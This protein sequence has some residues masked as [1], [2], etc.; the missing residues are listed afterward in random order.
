VASGTGAHLIW[1]VKNGAKSLPARVITTL[2]D[3]THLVRLRESDSMLKVRR[4]ATGDKRALRLD[5]ITARLVEFPVTTTDEA[6]QS[7]TTRFRVLTT[8]LNPKTH[9]AQEI[10]ACYAERWQV[11]LTYKAIKSTLRGSGRRLRGQAPDLA[12]QEIWALLTVCNALVDQA[13]RAAVDLGV[14]PD[15]ISL[16][17]VLNATRDH[18]ARPCESCGHHASPEDLT[19]A[20]VAAPRNRTGR[21]RTAPR[22]ARDRLT[23]HA[24]NVTYT[25]TITETNLPKA[26]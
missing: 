11:E 15:E 3:G 2:S 23:Q 22:T 16:T 7:R 17:V 19:A 6:G 24:R 1:R 12:E 4:K 8:L 9:P 25:I 5:D 13:I 18:L 14:D 26:A 20:I 10:A 21:I